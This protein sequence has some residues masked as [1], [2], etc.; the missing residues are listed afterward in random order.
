MDLNRVKYLLRAYHRVRLA[1][2]R[3]VPE[4]ARLRRGLILITRACPQIEEHVLHYISSEGGQLWARLSPHEQ[5]F[6]K[7][8][9]HAACPRGA[10]ARILSRNGWPRY[11]DIVEEHFRAS[12]LHALPQQYD[13]IIKQ[14]DDGD[15]GAGASLDMSASRPS[16]M[17]VRPVR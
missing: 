17:L 12:V 5:E 15:D 10:P 14:I 11:T 13:S 8:C 3:R 6:A 7:G 4:M 16:H 1:K 9:V 2:V